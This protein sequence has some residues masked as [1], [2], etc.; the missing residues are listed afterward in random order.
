MRASRCEGACP[1]GRWGVWLGA[2]L[3]CIPL[4][5]HGAATGVPLVSFH[6]NRYGFKLSVPRDWRVQPLPADGPQVL[7]INEPL[8][9]SERVTLA[10]RVSP[11][12]TPVQADQ[13]A[14]V[15]ANLVKAV[16]QQITKQLPGFR[17]EAHKE[18]RLPT[19]T[20]A[21]RLDIVGEVKGQKVRKARIIVVGTYYA[22]FFDFTFP[23]SRHEALRPLL[24]RIIQSIWVP[25]SP[26]E[27]PAE[28]APRSTG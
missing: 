26:I 23:S 24:D 3:G 8:A 4:A 27:P 5:A 28:A 11:S 14:Q 2:A 15:L 13:R 18:L 9:A 10:V 17:T 1:I 6:S 21:A 25:P 12:P 7:V 20:E 16:G 19:G 22:Y